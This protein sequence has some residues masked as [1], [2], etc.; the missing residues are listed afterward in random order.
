MDEVMITQQFVALLNP[1]VPKGRFALEIIGE[2]TR[3]HEKNS[4]HDV[5]K[6]AQKYKLHRNKKNALASLTLNYDK[7][8]NYMKGN[9][10]IL[11]IDSLTERDY[12]KRFIIISLL[13][14]FITILLLKIS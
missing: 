6:I 4:L 3:K 5:I 9:H 13:L 11:K 8:Y 12:Q 10:I 1:L 14:T 2:P 7:G